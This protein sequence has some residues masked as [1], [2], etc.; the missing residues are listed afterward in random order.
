MRDEG[1]LARPPQERQ[2][3]WLPGLLPGSH[4]YL[5]PTCMA[6]VSHTYMCPLF[7]CGVSSLPVWGRD[8]EFLQLPFNAD[9]GHQFEQQGLEQR[10]IWIWSQLG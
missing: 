5:S 7:K 10:V 9:A 4:T 2:A 8:A 6:K 1:T 3:S